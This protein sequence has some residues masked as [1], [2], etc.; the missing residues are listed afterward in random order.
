MIKLLG[1]LITILLFIPIEAKALNTTLY[2][3]S[4]NQTVNTVLGYKLQ[5]TNSDS[6]LSFNTTA[7]F[8]NSPNGDM[9]TY[10]GTANYNGIYA[11]V[12]HSDGSTTLLGSSVA[13]TQRTGQSSSE[14]IQN[15]TF[16]CPETNLVVTDALEIV[17]YADAQIDG[18]TGPY[19]IT[20][21]FVSNQ[22]GWVK[23]EATDWTIYRY[24]KYDWNS[25]H[26][27]IPPP[28][29]GSVNA[30][31]SACYATLSHGNSTYTTYIS[32]INYLLPGGAYAFLLE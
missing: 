24:S 28:Y 20:R 21:T 13:N 4:D 1:L 18:G 14:G 30:M 6:V 16:S 32:G 31:N 29:C 19:N 2:M 8:K 27:C 9:S 17:L 7:S 23:L 25:F 5:E 15:S 3:R 12:L 22:L 10:N 11:Y 26:I